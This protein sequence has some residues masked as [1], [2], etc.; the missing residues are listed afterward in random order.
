MGASYQSLT[1]KASSPEKLKGY[2]E[3]IQ[4]D[5][6]YNRGHDS[7]SG[8]IGMSSGLQV[9]SLVF[10]NHTEA[11]DYVMEH[12]SKWGPAIAVKVGDFSKIFPM[13]I[14]EKKEWEKLQELKTK[15]ENW[16]KSLIERV[17]K[18]KSLHRGCKICGSK[19]AVKYL[20]TKDCPICLDTHFVETDTD[21]KAYE[22]FQKKYK[23]QFQKVK[24]MEKKYD[25]KNKNNFWYVGAWC[26][27]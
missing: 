16:D 20:R 5:A 7:Y 27:S 17:K 23:E 11:E 2:F 10:K 22:Q 13:T 6:C 24:E 1:Y 3:K 4:N 19:I 25:E 8:H 15:V 14:T 21:K 12:A 9:S 18:T 26:A